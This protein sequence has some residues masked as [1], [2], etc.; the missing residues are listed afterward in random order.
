MAVIANQI[1][2]SE[3]DY[4]TILANLVS[5]MRTDPAFADYDFAG[6]GLRLLSRVLA[7]VVF[8]QNYY[9]SVAVNESFL[10]TAQLRSSVVAH[11]RMLGYEMT[12]TRGARFY[13]NT[14]V[15]L[16][17]TSAA[18][19]VLPQLTQFVLS[20]NAG[21][22]FYSLADTTL[23]KNATTGLYESGEVLLVEGIPLEYRFTANTS[24]PTQ[25]FVIPNANIDYTTLTVT[26]QAAVG[27][28]VVT[29]FNRATNYL[30]ITPTDPVFFV[31]EAYD[32]YPELKFGNDVIGKSLNH[33]NIITVKYFVSH[34][35]A[36]NNIRGPFRIGTT[37][38]AGF[39]RGATYA[40]ANTVAS[41]GGVDNEAL[42]NARFLAPLVY[43]TQNRCVTAEDYKTIILQN[44]G[45]AIDAINVFGG[46]QGDPND[47]A[48]RPI[49]GRVFIAIK[50][51]IGL[52]FTDTIRRNI[53]LQILKPRAVIGVIPVVIDP[54]YTYINISSAVKY[55]PK[56]ITK[57]RS[58][59]QAAIANNILAYTQNN[60]EKFD[61]AFR[62]SRFVRVID[63]TD[64]SIV[65]SLSR[66]DLEKRIY[67]TLG[68]SNQFILKF[69]SP[70]RK[71]GTQSVVLEVTSHRFSYTN[72]AGVTQTNCFLYEQSG[73]LHVAYRNSTTGVV[74]IFKY[75]IGTVDIATGLITVTNFIPVAIENNAIDI[76]VKI[77]PTVND[78]VPQLNQLFTIDP[79][80]IQIELLNDATSTAVDQTNFFSGG[81]L[82]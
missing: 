48:N 34:G 81:I 44:Y 17:D 32:G 42:D 63:D 40:D 41:L 26:V 70:I 57:S 7:Y 49:F 15:Q 10:D 38:L 1:Q 16:V 79:A 31:Q 35:L 47:P 67:P 45:D 13:A 3:L 30:I 2:I 69:N 80:D 43:Q 53:E 59:L 28:S 33:G 19:I 5:F 21:V 12:G 39:V 61:T 60:V 68:V 65:S 9:L 46:E 75:N 4:D 52:R 14:S 6:S 71:T 66:V 62:F 55:D 72:D 77:I 8:Y 78:F 36:G 23:V 37:T 56:V 74:T 51:K 18:A 50:P 54:D 25:R 64:D 82:P 11:A 24:D 73:N 22:S 58:Q 29:N 27:S 76:R 20:A